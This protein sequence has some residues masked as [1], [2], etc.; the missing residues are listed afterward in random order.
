MHLPT[1]LSVVTIVKG[2]TFVKISQFF[3][4]NGVCQ[5]AT[6]YLEPGNDHQ[7]FQYL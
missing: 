6:R 2:G 1:I 5:T 7:I 4:G 3:V